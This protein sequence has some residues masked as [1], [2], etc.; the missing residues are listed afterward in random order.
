MIRPAPYIEIDFAA[1]GPSW[2]LRTEALK[3]AMTDTAAITLELAG[4]Q[5]KNVEISLVFA[6]DAFIRELNREYRNKDKPTNVLSF[7]QY[8]PDEVMEEKSF[9]ALGDIIL[10][11][12]TIEREAREQNKSFEDHT[13]HLFV[14]GLLHLLG[15]DHEEDEEAEAMENLE[16]RILEKQGIKNPYESCEN[17]R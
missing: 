8:E 1:Q 9:L 6:D 2:G 10:A 15:H 11:K 4:I 5:A 7:P 3:P 13:I 12:E 16:I 17:M 14:H